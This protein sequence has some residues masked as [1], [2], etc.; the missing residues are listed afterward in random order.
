MSQTTFLPYQPVQRIERY[1]PFY[2]F[3]AICMLAG[4]LML[5][6][7]LHYSPLRPGNLFLL[8]TTLNVYEA[9]LI[10][11]G[12]FLLGRGLPRD[13]ATLLILEAFFLVDAGFLNSEA[14]TL[15]FSIGLCVNLALLI[16]AAI[17]V[18]AVFRALNFRLSD[19]RYPLIL[20]V[21]LLLLSAPGIF[22]RLATAHNGAL[23]QIPLYTFWWI[24]GVAVIGCFLIGV[25]RDSRII[26]TFV[27]LPLISLIA[28]LGTTYWVYKVEW[29]GANLSP[30]VLGIAVAVGTARQYGTISTARLRAAL[31]LPV[32]AIILAAGSSH[33]LRFE[34]LNISWTPLRLTLIASAL[35]YAHA[36]F[37]HRKP[38]LAI[39][40]FLCAIAACIGDNP[41]T[42]HQNV[43]TTGENTWNAAMR[44]LPTTLM[45]WGVIAVVGAFV[46]LGVGS[47][48]SLRKPPND[49]A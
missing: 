32:L 30:F 16:L 21:M 28:H 37:V 25:R 24:V 34:L 35:V 42:I 14:F 22:K 39:G 43:S 5:S 11:L 7:S 17:K 36:F 49:A 19:P 20:F 4:I 8:I 23:S 33:Q 48:L 31:A 13:A 12:I 9:V 18:A 26:N 3:S 6:N 27:L 45:Q 1:N 29:Q 2:L 38:L 40:G 15:N 44:L 46:L 47:A 10:L 41:D